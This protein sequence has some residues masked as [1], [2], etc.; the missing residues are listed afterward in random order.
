MTWDS[1]IRDCLLPETSG[2]ETCDAAEGCLTS[3][4]QCTLLGYKS[5]LDDPTSANCTDS[6]DALTAAQFEEAGKNALASGDPSIIQACGAAV[7]SFTNHTGWCSTSNPETVCAI[8][9][10][11]FSGGGGESCTGNSNFEYDL[12]NPEMLPTSCDPKFSECAN[13]LQVCQTAVEDENPDKC[14]DHSGCLSAYVTCVTAAYLEFDDSTRTCTHDGVAYFRQQWLAAAVDGANVTGI[15]NACANLVCVN[16][17]TTGCSLDAADFCTFSN[18]NSTTPAPSTAPTAIPAGAGTKVVT[19]TLVFL[20][21]FDSLMVSSTKQKQLRDTLSDSLTRKLRYTTVVKRFSYTS[22]TGQVTTSSAARRRVALA[23]GSLTAT[24]EAVV[25]ASDTAA[26][27]ALVASV[28]ALKSDTST[29]WLSSVASLC[30]CTIPPPTVSLAI[31]DGGSTSTEESKSACATGCIAGVVGGGVA[32]VGAG[33]GVVA[34]TSMKKSAAVVPD[35][36]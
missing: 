7:C 30:G 32:A 13:T 29:D 14:T 17:N 20:A 28:D 35:Q 1:E 25:P 8:V 34:Y 21:D 11:A 22:S 9:R 26:L 36:K 23:A 24:A 10:E 3:Y 12:F 18:S 27:N 4:L 19:I 33:V 15:D 2:E 16:A 31:T 6:T 5:I